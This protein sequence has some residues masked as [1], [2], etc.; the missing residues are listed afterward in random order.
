MSNKLTDELLDDL[1]AALIPR[2]KD[3]ADRQPT[4]TRPY[5]CE[6]YRCSRPAAYTAWATYIAD[7]DHCAPSTDRRALCRSHALEYEAKHDAGLLVVAGRP[8]I[9]YVH[10]WGAQ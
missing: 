3:L 6:V 2:L 10:R 4:T 9:N 8:V 5:S 1:A 7:E